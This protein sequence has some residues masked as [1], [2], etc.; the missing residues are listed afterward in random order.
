M[1]PSELD[2]ARQL[3]A[4]SLGSVKVRELNR[5]I[6]EDIDVRGSRALNQSHVKNIIHRFNHEGCRRLDPLTW[7]PCEVSKSVLQSLLQVDSINLYID[8]PTD[9]RLPEGSELLCLQGQHRIA[10]AVEWLEPN[11][12][13]WNL[14]LYDS[15]K[16]SDECRKRLR[17]A[18]NGS[19]LFSD[20]EI[21][22]NVRHYQL[23]GEEKPAQEWLAKWSQTKCRDYNRIYEPKKSKEKWNSFA[24]KLDALLV[25]PALWI[26][27]LMGTHLT[28]L[29][30]PE[31]KE[32]SAYLHQ[33]HSAWV[34]LTCGASQILDPST[35]ELLQGRYPRLSLDDRRFINQIFNDNLAFPRVSD[36]ALRSQLLQASLN[37]PGIIPSLHLFLE[38]IK[39]LKPMTDILKKVLPFKFKGSIRQAMLRY[40]VPTARSRI[41]VTENDFEED[42]SASEKVLFWSAYRQCFLFAMRHFFGLT[43]VHP[44]GHSQSSKPHQKLERLDLWKRLKFLFN[45]LGFVLDG[46]Q[47]ARAPIKTEYMAIHALLAQL[48]PPELFEYDHAILTECSNHVATVLTQIKPRMIS[49][50]RPLQSTDVTRNWSLMQRCGM[51][52]ADTFFS[53]RKYLFLR[54]VYSPD[55]EPRESVTS[56]AVKRDIFRSF[57]PDNEDLERTD[58]IPEAPL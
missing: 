38:N 5:L 27:W 25:F 37:Y 21:F 44:R 24:K 36:P 49:A 35:L 45:H 54:N 22:Q 28:S 32:L 55:D 14:I 6:F 9:L 29:N 42:E 4:A 16:L 12:I 41:Q 50:P 43:D 56:F 18:E 52:D 19:Q 2:I 20:G 40:Y 33:I 46:S 10:A 31:I 3:D 23:R 11:D 48:R 13:W 34:S 53:D 47:K 26:H 57:F 15:E 58:I 8:R 30:S 17:E 7:I 1:K 51:T 39:Y